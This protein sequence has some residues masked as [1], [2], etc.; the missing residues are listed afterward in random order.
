MVTLAACGSG[1][2]ASAQSSNKIRVGL[3]LEGP[4]NDRSFN[5]SAYRGVLE[6]QKDHPNIELKSVLEN[7]QT[8]QDQTD[9]VETLAPI[10]D[11]VVGA[12][13]QY[14]PIYDVEAAK[15]PNTKF[16]TVGG[17][18]THKHDNVYS[19]AF[20]RVA[21]YV[22]GV[23]SAT[24]TKRGT[25]GFIGG[26]DIPPTNASMASFKAGVTATNSSVK[27]LTNIVGDFNDV[28]K[29][30]AATEAMLADG[31]DVIMSYLDAGVV[32]SYA[33]AKDAGTN[34]PILKIDQL[35]CAAYP[36]IVGANIGDNTEAVRTLLD[37]LVD[38]TLKPAGVT[39][40]AGVQDPKLQ[41][42]DLCPKYA[43]DPKIS[44]LVSETVH[45]INIGEIK[46]PDGVLNPRPEGPYREGVDGPVQNGK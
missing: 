45:K 7:R 25:V 37:G 41:R 32:G 43:Q 16:L 21:A 44:K 26:A 34:V 19:L 40:F 46:M 2:G 36:N 31:A 24:L 14:G 9:A 6:A 33:A 28:P 12:G 30:K 18:P 1:Q 23:L 13:A 17:Y 27:V 22:T 11:V 15:F 3:I 35:E 29:G 42:V 38:K 20:D 5:E 4:K 39:I 10:V 8:T